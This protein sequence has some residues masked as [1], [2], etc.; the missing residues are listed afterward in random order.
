MKAGGGST[1]VIN[2]LHH[3]IVKGSSPAD[4]GMEKIVKQKIEYFN[5]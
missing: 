5:K 1:V 2:L 4:T 3:P